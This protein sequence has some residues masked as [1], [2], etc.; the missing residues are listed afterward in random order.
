LSIPAAT[1]SSSR[2]FRPVVVVGVVIAV[3][4]LA[5]R[6]G[7]VA[8]DPPPV[9]LASVARDD[10]TQGRQNAHRLLLWGLAVAVVAGAVVEGAPADWSAIRLERL[11]SSA[12]VA[13]LGLAAFMTGMLAGRLVGDPLTDRY[14]GPR[15]LRVGMT[16]AAAGFLLG[17]IVDHPVAFFAGLVLAGA[18]AAGFFPLAF[19]AAGRMPGVAPGTGA[20]VV[21]MGARVGYLVEPLLIGALAEAVGL[22]WAFLAVAAAA[23]ALAVAGPRLVQTSVASPPSTGITVPVR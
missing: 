10:G 1:L 8:P 11:G 18:G 15:V 9:D 17:V 13:A 3:A 19:S 23:G 14:G 4:A 7:L 16:V 12:G 2:S 22:R 5:A 6:G 21:S 20:A